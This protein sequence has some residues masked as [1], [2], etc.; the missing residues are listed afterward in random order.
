MKIAFVARTV[1]L[2]YDD[3]IRKECI[4]LAKQNV[5]V[6]IYVNFAD[7]RAEEGVT[8]YGIP[9]RSFKLK[10][11][12]TLPS[13]KYLLVKSIDFYLSIRRY[14]HEYDLVWAHEEYT[15]IFPLL[16]KKNKCIWDLHEI[17]SFFE[18]RGMRLIFHYIE[19]KSK[20][21]IHAN[22]Y[23]IQ[24][25]KLNKTIKYPQKHVYIHN[26]PDQKFIMSEGQDDEYV[27]F[28]DWLDNAQY[29]YVQG[30]FDSSR[31]SFNT[32]E[33]IMRETEL[34]VIVVGKFDQEAFELLEKKYNAKLLDRIYFRGMVHQLNIPPYLKNA[35]FSIV[36]YDTKIPNNRYCEPNRLYQA[37]VMG[38][39]V[40]VGSNES[41]KEIVEK[42]H[43]G[44]PLKTDG[45]DIDDIRDGI[46]KLLENYSFYQ[47]SVA[48]NMQ[49]LIWS[50]KSI[51][52]DWYT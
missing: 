39:P 42:Y 26:Y 44:I 6:F 32:L 11:R 38:I 9:Y 34:K 43:Y 47:K 16:A 49:N 36:L 52:K 5:D 35:M 20:K 12:V 37:I 25:L 1:G 13:A 8:S 4:T 10:S 31:F 29:I 2:E 18:K 41:M 28:I 22:L 23:R 27:M 33:A 48:G 46:S 51:L 14:L 30:L 50:D 19:K 3:R 17:P 40:I 24:H 7:N 15:F 45:R 21:I